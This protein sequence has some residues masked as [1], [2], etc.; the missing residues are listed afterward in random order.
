LKVYYDNSY[1]YVYTYELEVTRPLFNLHFDLR[2]KG[3]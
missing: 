3:S 1:T 2:S